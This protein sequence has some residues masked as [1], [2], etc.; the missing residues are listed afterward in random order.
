L[1][2]FITNK[3]ITKRKPVVQS[4]FAKNNTKKKTTTFFCCK[5]EYFYF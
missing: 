4:I 5:N 3:K 1:R 2:E